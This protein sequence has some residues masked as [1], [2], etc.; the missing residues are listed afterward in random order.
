M[1][2]PIIILSATVASILIILLNT[3]VIYEY[4][5]VLPL[6][7]KTKFSLLLKPYEAELGNYPN[8]LFYWAA[9]FS[10]RPLES[11]LLKIATCPYCAGF[12]LAAAIS[13]VCG[14]WYLTGAIYFFGLCG[15]F[16]IDKISKYK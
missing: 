9:I 7:S 15:Y 12:W 14:Y 5:K 4:L 2:E 3:D 16:F 6:S 13:V 10:Q 1:I 11:F 8:I